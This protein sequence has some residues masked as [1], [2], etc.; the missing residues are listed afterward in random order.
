[1]TA[2]AKHDGRVRQPEPISIIPLE[3]GDE[4]ADVWVGLAGHHETDREAGRVGG[5]GDEFKAPE[6]AERAL[7]LQV[8]VED[9]AWWKR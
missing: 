7:A 6:R 5:G 1:M 2:R 4:R 8:H 9:D 3:V